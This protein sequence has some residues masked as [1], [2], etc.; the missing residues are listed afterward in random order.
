M[1]IH[2]VS[3]VINLLAITGFSFRICGQKVAS[4]HVAETMYEAH[5]VKVDVMLVDK[6]V[7]ELS[8]TP[9]GYYYSGKISG[10]DNE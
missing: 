3:A 9:A 4:L 8:K 6:V 5:S 2:N 7:G 10:A 1:S